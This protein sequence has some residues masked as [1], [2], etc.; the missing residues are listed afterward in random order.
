MRIYGLFVARWKTNVL[1]KITDYGFYY[2]NVLIVD[3][4]LQVEKTVS[5]KDEPKPIEKDNDPKID[6]VV[7]LRNS[8]NTLYSSRKSL[9]IKVTEPLRNSPTLSLQLNRSSTEITPKKPPM[10][11]TS[12]YINSPGAPSTS[13]AKS[14]VMSDLRTEAVKLD[15]IEV[16]LREP[17]AKNDVYTTTASI[18]RHSD[19][20]RTAKG[21]WV[22]NFDFS[23]LLISNIIWSYTR[24]KEFFVVQRF[25]IHFFSWVTY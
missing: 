8:Q 18:H 1:M 23:F 3:L 21:N 9:E 10:Y 4:V 16:V 15:G 6:E 19:I 2:S 14:P 12:V 20:D 7:A 13:P 25:V 22:S 24:T 17:V 5:I 11:T